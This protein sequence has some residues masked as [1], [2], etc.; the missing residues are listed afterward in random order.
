MS[1]IAKDAE[2]RQNEI[3]DTAQQLFYSKGYRRTSIQDIIDSVGIAKGTFYYYFRSKRD[4][5]DAMINRILAQS[6]QSLEQ[7]VNDEELNAVEKFNLFFSEG[8][9]IKIENEEIV[10]ALME[11]Y[12]QDDNALMREKTMVESLRQISPLLTQIIQQGVDE[13]QFVTAYPKS[14]AQIVMWISQHMSE[15]VMRLFLAAD[16]DAVAMDMVEGNIAAHEEAI[17]RILGATPGSIRIA[18]VENFRRWF[19]G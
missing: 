3:L 6:M 2:V 7:M 1:R 8:A 11:V 5:L 10:R 17:S 18:N 12:Y 14:S 19:D 16:Q 15:S 9:A 4:L 13:G